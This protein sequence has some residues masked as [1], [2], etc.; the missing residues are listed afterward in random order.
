MRHTTQALLCL[1]F[2]WTL[3]G[4][5]SQ[6]GQCTRTGCFAVFRETG[7]F[8]SAKERC[9]GGHGHLA[10]VKSAAAHGRVRDL[11]RG[12]SGRYW[13]GLR[14]PDNVCPNNASQ[15]RGYKWTTGD[16]AA[17]FHNWK[18]SSSSCSSQ[19]VSVS[20]EDDSTWW[21]EPCSSTAAGFLCEYVF[22]EPCDRLPTKADERVTYTTPMVLEGDLVTFPQ[23]SLA[24]KT[25]LNSEH[26]DSKYICF[27]SVWMPAP[28]NCDV[29]D[30]GCEDRCVSENRQHSCTC[31]AGRLLHT[32]NITCDADPCAQCAPLCQKEDDSD[33]CRCPQGYELQDNRCADI[34]ECHT[35][36]NICT[37][38][39]TECVNTR[40]SFECRCREGFDEE[41]GQCVNI[42]ICQYCEHMLCDKVKG[43][44]Q[45]NCREGHII[46]PGNP[47]KCQRHCTQQDCPPTCITNKEKQDC[48]CPD[49]YIK[50]V[51]NET[52]VC[53]DIDECVNQK[54]CDHVCTNT[55]GS[56]RC[57]CE[58]GFE[59][60]DDR[61]VSDEDGSGSTPPYEVSTPNIIQPTIIPSYVKAGSVLGI[62]VFVALFMLLLYLV[63]RCALR[64]CGKLEL[65]SLKDSGVDIF[66]LQQ[67][68]TERYK[69]FSFDKTSKNDS[70]RQ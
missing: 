65:S 24:I 11:L 30:G 9:V 43:V 64:R 39:D 10:T 17:D 21:P 69:R 49:G 56:Y 16:D 61:C 68:T 54:P 23:G 63:V 1:C 8:T 14:L 59:S 47:T 66:Y 3:D 52:P 26:L 55:Y 29:M 34:N 62:A 31:P 6:R 35:D 58:E 7:N 22:D 20:A 32:N 51:I 41:D 42:T 15:L 13:I 12:F 28:W 44:Y 50:D 25:R 4:G 60:V 38:E 33:V 5:V 27:S 19:C 2:L 53:T 70:Q 57:S 45:C 37:D 36:L 46:S 67:V 40:G 48:F 18:E